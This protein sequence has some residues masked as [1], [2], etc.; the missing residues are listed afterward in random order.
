[1]PSWIGAVILS[2][3]GL[4]LSLPAGAEVKARSCGEVRQAYGAKG[5]SL[6]DIPYQEIAGKRGRAARQAAALGGRTS[7]GRPGAPL[8]PPVAELLVFTFWQGWLSRTPADA[9]AAAPSGK[10]CVSA[11]SLCAHAGAPSF[12]PARPPARPPSAPA[13][14]RAL[15]CGLGPG[16]PGSPGHPGGGRGARA[17]RPAG[18]PPRAS[19]SGKL[20]RTAAA[21]CP[22]PQSEW[23]LPHSRPRAGGGGGETRRA[24]L[25]A[26]SAPLSGSFR[27]AERPE[28]GPGGTPTLGV[29]WGTR[30]PD[31][32]SSGLVRGVHW[33][34]VSG[35]GRACALRALSASPI[36]VGHSRVWGHPPAAGAEPGP[37][38]DLARPPALRSCA[39]RS[40]WL[41]AGFVP[42]SPDPA[43]RATSIPAPRAREPPPPTPFLGAGVWV[44][45]GLRQ[46]AQQPGCAFS[47]SSL[48]PTGSFSGAL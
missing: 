18:R 17:G 13:P 24:P 27:E 10:V 29:G 38:R 37:E 32:G 15:R 45:L 39:D 31:V 35:L 43:C 20:G 33:L 6:A 28:P 14:V 47:G 4:L 16:G 8:R 25:A 9:R 23:R 21:V 5:F 42:G 30:P 48:Q 1:M 11:A 40:G 34:P 46:L 41:T 22:A 12:P 19:R 3:S 7:P 44:A 2:L 36:A 26:R